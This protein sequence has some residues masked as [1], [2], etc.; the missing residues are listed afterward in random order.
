MDKKIIA[1]TFLSSI[2][3]GLLMGLLL[4]LADEGIFTIAIKKI[5]CKLGWH[6]T[7]IK[8]G[9]KK[10]KKYR[11]QLCKKTEKYP[12]LKVVD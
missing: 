11:C 3:F 6:E 12:K 2:T 9:E 10:V 4:I 7:Y 1:I 8:T 5:K